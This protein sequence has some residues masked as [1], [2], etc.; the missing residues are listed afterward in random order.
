MFDD[1]IIGVD[2]GWKWGAQAFLQA[3]FTWPL[4]YIVGLMTMTNNWVTLELWTSLK[5]EGHENILAFGEG[6]LKITISK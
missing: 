3:C 5:I 2:L 1:C 4:A 6:F